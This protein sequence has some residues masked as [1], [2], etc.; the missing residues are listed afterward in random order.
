MLKCCRVPV[1]EQAK[2]RRRLLFQGVGGSGGGWLSSV[3]DAGRGALIT[4]KALQMPPSLPFL[5]RHII[6]TSFKSGK[7]GTFSK[8]IREVNHGSRLHL[9]NAADNGIFMIIMND[10]IIIKSNI[11]RHDFASNLLWPQQ[12]GIHHAFVLIRIAKWRAWSGVFIILSVT[13]VPSLA[14]D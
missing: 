8:L 6:S 9:K 2:T 4:D 3:S 12:K 10:H 13:H 11:T 1:P 14:R 5:V 7:C